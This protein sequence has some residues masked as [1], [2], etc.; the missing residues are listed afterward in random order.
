M[1][2]RAAP[3]EY[4]IFLSLQSL[5]L[6]RKPQQAMVRVSMKRSSQ[7]RRLSAPRSLCLIAVIL[8][9]AGCGGL[10]IPMEP[11]IPA[12][13]QGADP[14]VSESITQADSVMTCQSIATERAGIAQSL[15]GLDGSAAAAS[16]RRR[17]A[18]L[19]RLAQLKR[20]S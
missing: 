10:K 20:C 14:A 16:L 3:A 5:K 1:A 18:T 9:L 6:P 4:V 11:D 8:A 17:D 7:K 19:A 15:A 13:D 12:V 2:R